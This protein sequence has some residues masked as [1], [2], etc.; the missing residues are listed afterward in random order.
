MD[1]GTL[2]QALALLLVIEGLLPLISPSGWRR[3]FEQILGLSNGQIRFFGL[4]SIAI[5]LIFLAMLA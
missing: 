2:W 3:M 1:S 5:G 4:C